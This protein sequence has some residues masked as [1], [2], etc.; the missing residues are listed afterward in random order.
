MVLRGYGV[1]I[2]L[3][4]TTFI[5][6]G[7]T[8]STFKSVPDQPV[9]SFELS[10]P[11][12]KFSALAANGNLCK[13]KLAMPT[14][15]VAQNGVKIN[16]S[17]PVSVTGCARKGPS[18][19]QKLAAALKKCRAKGKHARRVACEKA[20]RKRYGAKRIRKAHKGGKK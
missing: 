12:G 2:D 16:R 5:R 7:V 1:T 17:T 9:S 10:L 3:V 11:Q 20:A 14:E 8:S 13:S 19:G 18:R 6:N 15:F 4:G